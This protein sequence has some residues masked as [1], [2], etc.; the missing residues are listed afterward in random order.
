[1]TKVS[2]IMPAY[3]ASRYIDQSVRSVQYQRFTDWELLIVDDGSTDNTSTL[4]KKLQGA[5]ERVRY[6]YQKNKRLGAARN[7]GL[8]LACGEY[9]AFL[10][11]DDLWLPSMLEKQV[12]AINDSKADVIFTDGY[13]LMQE[14]QELIP[15]G[16]VTGYYSGKAMFKMQWDRNYIPVL[17]VLLRREL[18]TKVGFQSEDF[19]ILGCEDWDYWLRIARHGYSFYGIPEKLF[20]YRMHA[21]GMSRNIPTMQLAEFTALSNNID[22]T[23][24]DE[25]KTYKRLC[26]LMEQ[27]APGLMLIGRRQHACDEI[28]KVQSIKFKKRYLLA[29]LWIICAP[30]S[31]YYFLEYFFHPTI[32]LKKVASRI[33]N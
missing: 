14:T 33:Y 16:S 10:D 32:I 20:K 6:F 8:R 30:R 22:Y 12:N 31:T 25:V 5:D 15:Y 1:M 13:I 11:S 27:N 17:S 7:A 28:K 21:G 9:I 2:V 26:T 19:R 3:N 24:V 29:K 4:V 18:V 23:L